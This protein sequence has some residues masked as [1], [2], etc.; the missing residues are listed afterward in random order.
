MFLV[1]INDI[2]MFT[3]PLIIKYGL[4]IVNIMFG[5]ISL[6]MFLDIMPM[7]AILDDFLVIAVH[8]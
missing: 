5:I 8:P 1:M 2:S 7:F 4:K 3:L 6:C